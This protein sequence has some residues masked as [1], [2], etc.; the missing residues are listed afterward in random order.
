MLRIRFLGGLRGAN[1]MRE[2]FEFRIAEKDAQEYLPQGIGKTVNGWVRVVEIDGHDPL[3]QQIGELH[4][5]M[6]KRS[7]VFFL[8]WNI[9][10]E[11]TKEELHK[12]RFFEFGE[13]SALSEDAAVAEFDEHKACSICGAG[14]VLR[15]PLVL[16]RPTKKI[17]I[18]RT[19]EGELVVSAKV[20]TLFDDNRISGCEFNPVCVSDRHGVRE[21]E[22][23]FHLVVTGGPFEVTE[24]TQFGI[25][26]F[27]PDVEGEYRCKA[28]DKYGLNI[29]SEIHFKL[30][31]GTAPRDLMRSRGY[32][33]DRRGEL[34]PKYLMV[35]SARLVN[36]LREQRIRMQVEVAHRVDA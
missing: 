10:R 34:R 4:L 9:R 35:A 29:L 19:L 23:F 26:P 8:S 2:V 15:S 16:K 25:S 3:V 1:E 32:I 18:A 24:A 27:N 5:K 33:G 20:R 12:A 17:D 36:V 13:A 6:N 30:P 31:R 14:A 7:D 21:S 28:G 22:D 11:Y